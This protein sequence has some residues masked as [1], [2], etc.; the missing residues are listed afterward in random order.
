MSGDY[1]GAT[2]GFADLIAQKPKD[3]PARWALAVTLYYR[4]KYDSSVAQLRVLEAALQKRQKEH[5]DVRYRSTEF[6]AYMEAAAFA[7]GGRRD[8]ARASL[9]KALTENLAFYQAHMLLAD[10]ALQD[11]DT[12]GAAQEWDQARSLYGDDVVARR[13]YALFLLATGKPA[14][15]ESELRAVLAAEPYWV[16]AR[17][18]LARAVDAQ[19]ESRRADAVREYQD[20]LRRAPAD[21]PEPRKVVETRLRELRGA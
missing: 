7:A 11:G 10:L 13:R 4:A 3:L 21:P 14:D 16:D 9:Q 18:D 19:G 1:F 2:E 8:S 5:F 6:V 15:A 17:R 20:Y 12:A